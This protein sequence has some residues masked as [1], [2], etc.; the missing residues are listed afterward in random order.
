MLAIRLKR[1]GRTNDP[2][3]RIIVQDHRRSPKKTRGVVEYV[4]SYNAR[5]GKPQVN[6]ERIQYWLSQGAQASDTVH[7][8]LVDTKVISEKKV[9]AHNKKTKI[10]KEVPVVEAP[11]PAAP[12]AVAPV[13]AEEPAPEAEA[14][15]VE[16][17]A[18]VAPEVGEA[19]VAEE[20][21]PAA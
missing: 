6:A 20:E 5:H 18:E 8:I 19:P 3:F 15:V 16:A 2:S 13:V 21:A 14:P 11:K 7:N 1:V 17:P 12:V 4:G 9:N 10:V